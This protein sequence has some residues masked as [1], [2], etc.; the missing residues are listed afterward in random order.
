MYKGRRSDIM[1]L[2]FIGIPLFGILTTL[3]L[4]AYA[5]TASEDFLWRKPLIGSILAL[6][7]I[8]GIAAAIFPK[9]CSNLLDSRGEN[10]PA[11]SHAKNPNLCGTLIGHHPN[12]E[13][14]SAHL[15]TIRTRVSCAAC[16][17][18]LMGAVAALVGT[19]L[20]FFGTWTFEPF[21]F[22]AVLTGEI[23][24]AL[25][26]VQLKFK[27]AIRSALNAFFVFGAYMI[28]AGIDMLARNVF[29][30]LYL[31]SLIVLW[32]WTRTLLSQW[33]HNRICRACGFSY[34]SKKGES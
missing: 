25:G 7:C 9:R 10:A 32:I 13:E 14:Y 31:I 15:V 21:G 16:T 23:F 22:H 17:G 30:D 18:L 3:T 8:L 5:P 6:I 2:F 4:A 19:V 1:P 24:I 34:R 26:F 27:G 33:D 20:Y 11:L 12:C 29:I 28:L